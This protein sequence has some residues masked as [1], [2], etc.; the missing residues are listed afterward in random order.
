MNCGELARAYA[1]YLSIEIKYLKQN[2]KL[3]GA[4]DL[5]LTHLDS[6]LRSKL[7]VNLERSQKQFL[8]WSVC[9]GRG[10]KGMDRLCHKVHQL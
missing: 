7:L 6:S 5:F 4:L 8:I 3:K 9:V 10:R 2:C 1:L